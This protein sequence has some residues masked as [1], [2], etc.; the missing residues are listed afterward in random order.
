MMV[1]HLV[2]ITA[3]GAFLEQL[4]EERICSKNKEE[5]KVR[6]QSISST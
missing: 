6:T 1:L 4:K 3:L 5:T 2:H